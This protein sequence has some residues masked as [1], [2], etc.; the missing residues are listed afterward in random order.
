MLRL[1]VA[2]VV[3]FIVSIAQAA[4]LTVA[5]FNTESDTD[6]Q[7]A[8][9]AISIGEIGAF[10]ILA[11]QEVESA[12]ALKAYAE[13]AAAQ[14]GRWRYIVSE[15]GVNSDRESDFL[16]IVYRTDKFRQLKTTEIHFIRSRP[17]GS[18]YGEPDWSLRGALLLRLQDIATGAEFQIATVHLKCC[19][20]PGVRAHQAA[21][22][23]VEI[24]H[25]SE[26]P[27]ILLGDTN[28]PI[29]PG[30]EGPEGSHADAFNNLTSGANLVWVKPHNP[31]KTQ[32]DPSFNSMLDQVYAPTSLAK[33]AT[34]EIKFPDASYCDKD[35][36]GFSDH[37]PIVAVF[38]NALQGAGPTLT[39]GALVS[40][41]AAEQK[42]YLAQKAERPGDFVGH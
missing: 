28:I 13:A 12:Q 40:E 15:S 39:A 34:A 29:E 5:T 19:N 33:G 31:I 25:D 41:A 18:V 42:E 22:L 16:G 36:Q 9:V 2:T 3:S 32:C 30:K 35:A 10:D 7:P 26:I 21:L 4:D 11:L 14:G 6:T 20:E 23:A 38:P 17:D 8:K 27:T 37:R 1:F 24:V